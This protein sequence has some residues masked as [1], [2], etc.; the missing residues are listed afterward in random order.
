M[1]SGVFI[2]GLGHEGTSGGDIA[3]LWSQKQQDEAHEYTDFDGD[4]GTSDEDDEEYRI[5]KRNKRIQNNDEQGTNGGGDEHREDEQGISGGGDQHS[6]DE[7]GTSGGGD[8]HRKAEGGNNDLSSSDESSS[9]DTSTESVKTPNSSDDEDIQKLRKSKGKGFRGKESEEFCLNMRFESAGQFRQ[10]VQD[11]ALKN[12]KAIK[13]TRSGEK[14]VEARCS[15]KCHW[16]IYE[17]LT[18]RHEAFVIKRYDSEHKCSRPVRNKARARALKAL[19]GSLADHYKML[20]SYVAELKVVYKHGLFSI[21]VEG[22]N[23]FKRMFIGFDALKEGFLGGC[24]LVISLDAAKS[25]TEA[26]FN[27]HMYEMKVLSQVAHDDFIKIGS[28]KFCRFKISTLPKCV[29][30]DNNMSEYFNG[31]ISRARN[32][33]LI[34]MLEDI[35]MTIMKRIVEKREMIMKSDN[36]ICPKIREK[37]EEKKVVSGFC[38]ATHAGYKKFEVK[39]MDNNYVVDLEQNSCSCRMWELTD[40]P[41]P[42]VISSIH[43]LGEDPTEYVHEYFKKSTYLRAYEHL[44]QPLNGKKMWAKVEFEPILSPIAKRQTGRPKR[45]RN[46]DKSEKEKEETNTTK[47][48]KKGVQMKCTQCSTYG[49]NKRSCK[50]KDKRP[51]SSEPSSSQSPAKRPKMVVIKRPVSYKKLMH[52]ERAMATKG[53]G[54]TIGTETGNTYVH[55]P[56]TKV[57]ILHE[58]RFGGGQ[59][60]HEG[61]Q[62]DM[63]IDMFMDCMW[64]SHG[65]CV[66]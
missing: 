66:D 21:M 49:Q 5:V 9:S 50:N 39:H 64:I 51:V 44:I 29:I 20:S 61:T 34:D 53:F 14:N 19:S 62:I 15:A 35:R 10:V 38:I 57:R 54:V 25:T 45:A 36:T 3:K 8:Q 17:S 22:H 65:L 56:N 27:E 13:F 63:S 2:A 6:K 24:R 48:S 28:D 31:Y 58:G 7:Q 46:K 52:K 32:R 26:Q 43:W 47:M 40:I 11:Y 4:D 33:L 59:F 23:R 60:V 1:P 12:G 41:C 55:M 42:H 16:R 30:I 18:Q 37:I